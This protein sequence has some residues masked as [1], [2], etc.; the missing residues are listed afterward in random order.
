M[1]MNPVNP[2]LD[3][4]EVRSLAE[5]LLQ[6]V[7]PSA[8]LPDAGF[9]DNFIGFAATGSATIA[10]TRTASPVRP[11]VVSAAPTEPVKPAP[12]VDPPVPPVIQQPPTRGAFLERIS[13]FRDWMHQGFSATG[14]F[15]LDREGAVI[16]DES[17]HGK[18]HFLARSLA[19][20]ARRPGNVEANVHVKVGA[21]S[22]LEV[23]PVESP[24]GRLVLGAVVPA[25]L[26]AQ[27]VVKVMEALKLVASPTA[28]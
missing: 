27:A 2:W 20:A 28:G 12:P 15:I 16:F 23:I 14:V 21:E 3:P 25:P 5:R 17:G 1:T 18:L 19:L 4:V 11:E 8:T 9:D 10:V 22:V 26:A 6:P 13:R 7:G 24:Y